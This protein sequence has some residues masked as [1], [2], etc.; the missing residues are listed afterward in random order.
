MPMSTDLKY[1]LAM[2]TFALGVIV[3]FSSFM[4]F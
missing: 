1:A 3:V 2:T 4:F